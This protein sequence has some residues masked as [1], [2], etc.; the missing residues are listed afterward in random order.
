MKHHFRGRHTLLERDVQPLE[1]ENLD[2]YRLKLPLLHR[3]LVN[4]SDLVMPTGS[5]GK[6]PHT[7]GGAIAYK[8]WWY[9][10]TVHHGVNRAGCDVDCV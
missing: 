7:T 1:R 9:K 2:P 5:G 4:V 8:L 10:I 6:R 3:H